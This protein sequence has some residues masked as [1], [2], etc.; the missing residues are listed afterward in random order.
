[1]GML[2][3]A[4]LFS[5]GLVNPPTFNAAIALVIMVTMIVPMVMRVVERLSLGE[6]SATRKSH[7]IASLRSQ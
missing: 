4:Y 3:A 6:A 1:M 5:R 7:E 2:V